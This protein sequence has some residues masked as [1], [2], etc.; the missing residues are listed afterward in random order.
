MGKL[1]PCPSVLRFLTFVAFFPQLVAGPILRAAEFLPQLDG[2]ARGVD[3][4]ES[5]PADGPALIWKVA[6]GEGYSGMAVADGRLYTMY[7]KGETEHVACHDAASGKELWS[8]EI[9][10]R[11]LDDQGNGPR[12]T[13]VVHGKVVYALGAKGKLVALAAGT[14]EVVWRKDLVREL[15]ARSPQWGISTQPLIYGDKLYVNAGGSKGRS[16]AAFDTK[17]GELV[18][19]AEDDD[20]GYSQPLPIVVEGVPQILFFTAGALVSLDPKTGKSYWRVPWQTSYDVNAATPIFLPPD[21]VLVS[22]G[23]NTGSAVLRIDMDEGRGQVQ[24]VWESRG[25]KNQFSSSVVAGDYAYG[26][27]NRVLKC[28]D[29]RTGEE[30]WK[31]SDLGHG[32]LIYADGHLIVLGERGELVLVE[33]TPAAYIEKGATQVL[34]GKCWTAPTLAGGKLYVRNEREMKCLSV[35]QS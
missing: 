14:G 16:I 4:T 1:E 27:D 2:I 17:T 12:S 15:D 28:L 20:A 5:W 19:S 32:S 9:D 21:R 3:L 26:F 35:S 18:W 25:F 31:K 7:N 29:L 22:T 34:S 11:Y 24:R 10:S 23:Y 13:P 8:R 33:A 30:L 6:V